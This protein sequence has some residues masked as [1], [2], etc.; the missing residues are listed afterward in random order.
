MRILYITR[1]F[2]HSGYLVLE[3]L[4]EEKFNIVGIVLHKDSN[5]WRN[6]Y[7]RPFL[8]LLYNLSC[9]F[10]SAERLKTTDSEESIAKKNQIPILWTKSIKS[11]AFFDRLKSINP[12]II[13]LGGGWHELLPERVFNFPSLGCINTHPSLLPEFR[14]TSITRWQVLH[15]L[16]RSGST[17]HYVDDNFDTGGALAQK[18]ISI[19]IGTTPQKLFFMLGEVGAEIMVELLRSF[20]ANGRQTPFRVEHNADHYEYFK[21]WQWSEERLIIDW[22]QSFY[23]IYHFVLANTQES[24]KYLGPLLILNSNKYFIREVTIREALE[25][26]PNATNKETN[27]F[28][29][30]IDDDGT[31]WLY[32]A[33][34]LHYLGI[35]KLQK[36]DRFYKFR[37]A[38]MARKQ[39]KLKVLDLVVD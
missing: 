24:Y 6:R 5:R 28:V 14:G 11:D 1:H 34:E 38:R 17:I 18:K 9:S 36:F 21:K 15:G 12:D 19:P 2:N 29:N 31:I 16:R 8:T 7:F 13:V 3:K 27:V 22:A 23:D 20:E 30:S 33:G 25:H 32:R 35:K 10:Y 26:V 4:I 37:R 39:L